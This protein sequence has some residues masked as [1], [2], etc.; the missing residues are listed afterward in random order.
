[1]I[2]RPSLRL[3]L[4]VLFL[5]LSFACMADESPTYVGTASCGGCHQPEHAA[6]RGSHHDLAM[7]EP[8]EATVLGDFADVEFTAH[9]V[10]SRF[11]RKDGGWFVR[12]DGPD[13]ALHDYQIVYTFGWYPLQQY[14]IELPGGRLQSFGIAWDSRPADRGGQRWFHLYPDL[15]GMDHKHPLHWTS[16][17]Q[18]WNY[19]CAECHSTKLMKGY[20]LANDTFATTWAEIDVACE[21]CHGPGSLH[22]VQAERVR[23]GDLTAWDAAKGLVVDL[24][25]RDGGTWSI[26]P[27]TGKPQRSRP[28]TDHTKIELCARCHSRR[29]Q[30]SEDYVYGR[31]LGDTH[32]LALLEDHLYH[33]DGQILEEVYVYGSFIQS[34][35]YRA[36]VTCTDCHDAHSLRLKA[37]GDMVC[38]QCHEAGR[39]AVE[40]HHRHKPDSA[41]AS[42]VG[43]HMPQR[44]YM[45][46]DE[47]ADHSMRVPRP[48]LSV[49]LGTPNACNQCHADK[50]AQW[51][52]QAVE[53]WYGKDLALPAH[54]AEALHA[55]RTGAAD[56]GKRLLD[57]A[58][59]PAQPAI[60]R[61]TALDGLREHPD[62]TH[63]LAL[64]R[65]LGD[66]DPL[67]RGAA[68]RY[69]QVLDAETLF[70]L[71]MP[72]LD[73]PARV[74]RVDAARVLAP[75][76]RYQLP[77]EVRARIAAG[78]DAYARAQLATAERPES[79][80]NIGLVEMEQGKAA[81]AQRSYRTALRLDPAFAPAYVNLADL[82]R[83][84][85]S[86]REGE[87][88][89]RQGI[90]EA[91]DD[92][93]LHQALGLLLVRAGR[94]PDAVPE[95]ARAAALAPE[96]PRYA[97]VHA[98][99]VNETGDTAGAVA[100]LEAALDRHPDD[101]DLLLALT[102][103]NR[104]AGRK[105]AA[106]AYAQRLAERDPADAEA[107]QLLRELGNGP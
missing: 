52:A 23:S 103:V 79:H 19:Q 53:S 105:D 16:R 82:Y 38:A 56:A 6:W 73:D 17:E 76:M 48:D 20:D 57:L 99:A 33:A 85:G 87:E 88:V 65:L 90:D 94:L 80:L 31:P 58:V 18:N 37:D 78:L 98:I 34:K 10:T 7:T 77:D 47:R 22:V 89:L 25:D 2:F 15:K 5:G 41:G 86:D 55:G 29:G 26:D 51:A 95:L 8:S 46:V 83:A 4:L 49:K 93:D 59:E 71:A 27:K 12:T 81:A 3:Y 1:M 24:A 70:R 107:Q 66:P 36:G 91:P 106:F 43:C 75:L 60:A 50:D 92:A 21:A 9:G 72:M 39:Y 13:G 44:F 42:C 11:Y 40:A 67:V 54:Y 101:R 45:V 69:L 104:D 62:P 32:R 97:Y 28:R 64:P 30:I 84:L 74:V 61:A 14:L 102:T 63:Q 100:I 35:M 68:V 96:R